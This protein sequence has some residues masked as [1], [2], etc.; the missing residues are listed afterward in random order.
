MTQYLFS[1][2]HPDGTPPTGD[3]QQ[4]MKDVD[5]DWKQILALYD[6]LLVFAPT[7]VVRL[8]RAVAV[9]EVAGPEQALAQIDELGLDSYYLYH[10]IRAD[11]LR[12]LG[13]TAEAALAYQ[14]ALDRTQN[15]AERDLL[16]ARLAQ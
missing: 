16:A 3:L 10:A 2:Y 11:L 9:A 14:A 15:A 4:I 5:A 13:R 7:Q 8:N 6:Q 1:T 12:R